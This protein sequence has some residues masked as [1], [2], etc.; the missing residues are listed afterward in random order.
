V[1]RLIQP[2]IRWPKLL[3]RPDHLPVAFIIRLKMY[4]N[5]R[6][7][8]FVSG[9][10]VCRKLRW[11]EFQDLILSGDVRRQIYVGR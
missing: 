8:R 6:S 5:W 10:L 2:P 4:A 9:Q 1:Q 11:G 7:W 3:D